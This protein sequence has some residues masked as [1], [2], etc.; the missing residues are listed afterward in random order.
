MEKFYVILHIEFELGITYR[1]VAKQIF[2]SDF[3]RLR[4]VNF[5]QPCPQCIKMN[6]K[7][8]NEPISIK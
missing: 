4:K 8:N 3:R 2:S 7:D 5:K 1:P 6:A